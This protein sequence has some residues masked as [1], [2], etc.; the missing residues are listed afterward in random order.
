MGVVGVV[1]GIVK[2]SSVNVLKT[3]DRALVR[4]K[5]RKLPFRD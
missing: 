2:F 3:V 5:V 1:E 4:R